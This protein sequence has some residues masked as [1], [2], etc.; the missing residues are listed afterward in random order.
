MRGR[1][2]SL[3]PGRAAGVR[4]RGAAV[5]DAAPTCAST[6]TRSCAS[7]PRA[8]GSAWCCATTT[9]S[10]STTSPRL[11]GISSG[12]VKR[13]LSDGLAKM[14]IALADDGTARRPPRHAPEGCGR[15]PPNL[16]S[17]MNCTEASGPTGSIDL[18]R[19]IRRAR[20]RRTSE[21][22]GDRGRERSRGCG[23]RRPRDRVGARDGRR[24][25]DVGFGRERRGR[26][27]QPG[28][29]EGLQ[30]RRKQW[31]RDGGHAH[32]LRRTAYHDVSRA[33]WSGHLGHPAHYAVRHERRPC[34]RAPDQHRNH[35]R[36]GRDGIRAHR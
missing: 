12:A 24:A 21:G 31:N 36:S 19:V 29:A 1:R 35:P 30:H 10:R 5:A 14:A 26:E 11:L 15:C 7:S 23:D 4:A 27:R 25:P 8:S 32:P 22:R 33:E 16:S 34:H 9:T 3:A 6:C 17:A 18:D 28:T 20:A 2:R 13:Y